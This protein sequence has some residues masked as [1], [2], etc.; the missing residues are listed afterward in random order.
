MDDALKI[1]V[2][3]D[4]PGALA[5]LASGLEDLASIE[6]ASTGEEGLSLVAVIQPDIV[7]LDIELPGLSGFEVCQQIK[8]NAYIKS[9]SIIFITSHHDYETE[10]K[11]LET[12]GID[13]I[14][15]PFDLTLCRARV[16]NHLQ[17]KRHEQ[18]VLRAR[19]QVEDERQYLKVILNSIADGVI[20][21]DVK[22]N[23][24]FINPVAQRLT[25]W[26]KDSALGLYITDVMAI[27]DA[28]TNQVLPNPIEIALKEQR[29]VA[30]ALNAKLTNRMGREYRV[31]DTAAP[32]RDIKQN[33]IGSVIVFQ[34]VTESIALAT[35]MTHLA[36]HDQL[37]GLPNRMLLH[38]RVLQS[39]ARA[40][41][42]KKSL[43]LLLIDIDNFKY[44]NDAIGHTV[45]DM[46]ITQVAQRLEHLC[47]TESTVARVGGDEFVVML[48]E[49]KSANVT[50]VTAL[51]IIYTI[52]EPFSIAGDEHNL[53]VS[54]GISFYPS[55]SGSAE[56]LMRH[57]DTAMYRA[58]T[59][60]KNR[61][62]Y[63]STNLQLA[64]NERV[65][66][67]KL[68]RSALEEESLIVQFQPKFD[69]NSGEV[70]G[71]EALVRLAAEDGSIVP[72]DRF[73]EFAEESG[74]IHEL[75][76]QVLY[77]SIQT[78]KKLYEQGKG[79]KIAVNIAAQQ[80][81]ES[82]ICEQVERMLNEAALPSHLIEIEVT[83]SALMTDFAETREVLRKLSDLGVSIALDDFGTGY[84]S[85][86]YLRTFPLDVLKI[87]RSFVIDMLTDEQAKNIVDVIVHLAHSLN[88]KLVGEGIETEEH[89][90]ALKQLGCEEGQGYYFSRPLNENDF[91][92]LLANSSQMV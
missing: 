85:L 12:G 44:L 70:S 67:E 17:I 7:L 11:A 76:R 30:M 33:L 55:D 73:I 14:T 66:I 3:D 36:N 61:Y 56:E 39:I 24:T 50:D 47:D 91:F 9:P 37:T 51:N 27:T 23:V 63:F 53:S 58:K 16:N 20:A 35:Q 57:A 89:W 82:D 46:I 84:S 87:D 41:L 43:A 5:V 25:G 90:Q 75:G 2:I 79:T 52:Q 4:D 1:V 15:K 8:S 64:L 6:T 40:R 28:T 29:T 81:H 19:Q 45:G 26:H 74:L 62:C 69:L 22:G 88:L 71:A 48:P 31:E 78:A 13:F 80:F 42:T 32:I 54:I 92:S 21:T 18:A 10:R 77:K 86:S 65:Q 60:G 38:D 49:I 59:T 34:D 72:P 68:L 83:E